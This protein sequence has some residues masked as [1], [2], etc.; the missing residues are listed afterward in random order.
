MSVLHMLIYKYTSVS[1]INQETFF[2]ELNKLELK[3]ILKNKNLRLG[4]HQ[5]SIAVGV[6][7]ISAT[8]N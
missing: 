1:K 3:S 6:G 8:R 4:K 5:K 7:E 2:L